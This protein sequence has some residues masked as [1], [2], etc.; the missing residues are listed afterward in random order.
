MA[1]IVKIIKK[2][3]NKQR[4]CDMKKKQS[5]ILKI[6]KLRDERD[7]ILNKLFVKA[8]NNKDE[9]LAEMILDDIELDYILEKK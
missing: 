3:K 5:E 1:P 4:R 7:S 2:E 8:I 9:E 6:K